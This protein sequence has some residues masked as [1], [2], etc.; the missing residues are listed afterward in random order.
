MQSNTVEIAAF[1]LI[2]VMRIVKHD[3][4]LSNVNLYEKKRI[5]RKQ[6]AIFRRGF[7]E[8]INITNYSR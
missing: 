4:V 5:T 7:D 3:S 8:I 6:K 2:F 1:V